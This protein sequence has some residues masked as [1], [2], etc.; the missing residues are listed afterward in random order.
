MRYEEVDMDGPFLTTDVHHNVEIGYIGVYVLSRDG[1]NVDYVG[2]SDSN[3]RARLHKSIREGRGYQVFWF[4]YESSARQA[5]RK[6]CYLWHKYN[7]PDNSAHPKVP[8][9][10]NWKCPIEG[11]PW[12]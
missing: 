6:E 10:A 9:Y 12:D 2:R 11:C 4:S 3:V 1:Q 7:P 5:Y 8:D